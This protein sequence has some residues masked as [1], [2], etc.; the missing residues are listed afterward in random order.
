MLKQLTRS[1]VRFLYYHYLNVLNI[2][3]DRK[4]WS[5]KIE[6]HG[7]KGVYNY[8]CYDG[9]KFFDK[10]NQNVVK[11]KRFMRFDFFEQSRAHLVILEDILRRYEKIKMRLFSYFH[12]GKFYD[13]KPGDVVLELGAY[14]GYFALR[15]AKDVGPTGRVLA[16]E[17]LPTNCEVLR[18]NVRENE[19]A[20]IDVFE[21]A[22][23]KTSKEIVFHTS[24]NQ[25]NSI[26]KEKVVR[27]STE[28][29]VQ[30]L[31]ID[32]LIEKAGLEKID[33]VRVQLNGV[34][35]EALEGFTSVEEY[36]P[37][38]MI[39]V[40]YIKSDGVVGWLNE[41]NYRY[42]LDYDNITAYPKEL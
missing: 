27:K 36:R 32:D 5:G 10:N 30:G 8:V 39:A 22:I 38:L 28:I 12:Y 42:R 6:G 35:Q 34:E 18:M 21:N 20:Q 1:K 29:R 25:L 14:K 31:S 40:P 37:V 17:P 11:M 4:N 2:K 23:W 24:E 33:F 7:A 13:L 26:N 16:V 19:L 15:A 3:F 9:L 41:H